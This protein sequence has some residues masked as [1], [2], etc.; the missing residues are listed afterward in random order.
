MSDG[1][2]LL[3]ATGVVAIQSHHR[4]HQMQVRRGRSDRWSDV[5]D[6][7]EF[8]RIEPDVR[9]GP[10]A[11]G[12]AGNKGRAGWRGYV[13]VFAGLD[14]PVKAHVHVE[15]VAGT[16]REGRLP[17]RDT[18]EAVRWLLSGLITSWCGMSGM[19]VPAPT[20]GSAANLAG[21]TASRCGRATS[22]A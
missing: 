15:E 13:L 10:E 9:D 19:S 11:D 4:L 8:D 18:R 14:G 3:G 5:Y 7:D 1:F 20:T 12:S 22:T 16:A 2:P 6:A 21:D 17:T